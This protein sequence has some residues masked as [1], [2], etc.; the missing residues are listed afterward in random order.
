MEGAAERV[1]AA[2]PE[3]ED[4]GMPQTV[5]I[6]GASSGIGRATAQYFQQ[7]GWNVAASMRA[8][9]RAGDWVRQERMLAVP[10]D[11]TDLVSIREGLRAAIG[12]FGAIDVLVNNAGYGLVGPFEATTPE[13]VERQLATN[14]TGLM[15][16]TREVL[17]HFRERRQGVLINVSSMG[18]RVTFPLYS[19]YHASKWAVEGFS[20]ALVYELEPFN[21]RVKIVEPGPIKTDF[22]D[23]SID[24]VRRDDLT[25]YDA[26]V[27]RTLPNLQKAGETAP[28]PE[29]A[30]RVIFKAATDGSWRLR[31]P[32]NSAAILWLRRLVPGRLFR[33]IV[34]SQVV[35]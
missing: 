31:Y 28:G 11:V 23:R 13:Q 22:Y 9:E 27:S 16:V 3:E 8:P 14:V 4:R 18:G 6:T 34:R 12:R 29:V 32:A 25:A 2:L 17:P 26:F 33:A 35:K 19:V 7:Q 5:F 20:E 15:N 24:L 21:I 30:A 1:L 10:L